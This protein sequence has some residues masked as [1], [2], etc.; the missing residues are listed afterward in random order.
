[1]LIFSA[2]KRLQ[3]ERPVRKKGWVE[4]IEIIN[5]LS[6]VVFSGWRMT[7]DMMGKP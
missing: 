4:I 2:R 1:M 7:C 5:I 3:E 6:T